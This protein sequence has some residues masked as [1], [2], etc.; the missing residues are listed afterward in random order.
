MKTKELFI[1]RH[2]EKG[3]YTEIETEKGNC[4]TVV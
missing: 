4:F 2:Y 3:L 1:G